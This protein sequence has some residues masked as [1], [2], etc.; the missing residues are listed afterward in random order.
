MRSLKDQRASAR[1]TK[2][3]FVRMLTR[4]ISLLD[5]IL[6]LIDNAVDAA[7]EGEGQSPPPLERSDRLKKYN[8]ELIIN[9]GKFTI[10]DNCGGISLENAVNYAFA[11][12]RDELDD[13]E[14]YAVGVYGIGMKRAIFKL[15]KEITVRSTTTDDEP[16]VVPINV[17]RWLTD[18]KSVW[19]F[20]LDDSPRLSEPGVE[21]TVKELSN[22]TSSSFLDPSFI[23]R[24]CQTIERDYMLPLMHGLQ[25]SVNGKRINGWDIRVKQSSDYRTMRESYV[26]DGVDVEI[27]AGMSSAPPDSSDAS[28]RS[29]QETSGWHIFCNGRAIVAADRTDLT[30]WGKDEFPNWHPQYQGFLGLLF[31]SSSH[32]EKLPMTTTKRSVDTASSLYKRALVKMRRPTR[33]WIDYTNR[34]KNTGPDSQ[35]REA[36]TKPVSLENIRKEKS[37]ILP[38]GLKPDQEKVANVNF[39]VPV[40]KMKRLAKEF[41]RRT[42]TYRDVGLRSF[43]YAYERLVDA[44]DDS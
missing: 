2:A 39:A 38:T 17:S 41:G 35:A 36:L 34:R 4:D 3:F 27:I 32:P 15:G 21:I 40:N 1:P 18:T 14:R 23:Q 6:D 13:S 9:K 25:I 11:F 24:L 44:E 16:F 26:D 8:I 42:M 5:C 12:G 43:N 31:F 28:D 29:Y 19:D 7:W 30:V 22:E 37:F 33:D 20:D 10:L